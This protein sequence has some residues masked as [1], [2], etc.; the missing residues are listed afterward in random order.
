MRTSLFRGIGG[1]NPRFFMYGEDIDLCQRVREAGYRVFHV[2]TAE[3]VHHGG[4][5][6]AQ[7]SS[8]FSQVMIREWLMSCCAC[9]EENLLRFAAVD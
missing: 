8:E 3:V 6:S 4:V 2:P 1:F 9:I 5:S 7:R